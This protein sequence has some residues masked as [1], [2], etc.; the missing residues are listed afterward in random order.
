[1]VLKRLIKVGLTYVIISSLCKTSV[2]DAALCC[3]DPV[4]S[5]DGLIPQLL[6]QRSAIN[7]FPELPLLKVSPPNVMEP[8]G[9][10]AT[11]SS[12]KL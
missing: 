11:N 9:Q 3:Q 4:F 6:R 10:P 5:N 12:S 1:M 8:Q 2:T 7:L